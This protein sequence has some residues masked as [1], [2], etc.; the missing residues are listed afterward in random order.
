MPVYIYQCNDCASKYTEEQ[1]HEMNEDEVAES[2][3][4][5]TYHGMEPSVDELAKAVICPRCQGTECTKSFLGVNIRGYL[6][7]YGWKDKAGAKRDMHV[8]HL[9]NQDPY[10][11]HR[12]PG[13]TDHIRRQLKDG[14][15]HQANSKIFIAPKSPDDK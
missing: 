5:E 14:G 1:L 6:R 13:E 8:Y 2:I 12:V 11:K 10:S 3:L 7:G 15:K 4:F 9:D